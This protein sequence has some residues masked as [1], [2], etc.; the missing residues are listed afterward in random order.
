MRKW[1]S[2]ENPLG[3]FDNPLSSS[4]IVIELMSITIGWWKFTDRK[5]WGQILCIEKYTSKQYT[6]HKRGAHTKRN[7]I[8]INSNGGFNLSIP[9]SA[10]EGSINQR[11]CYNFIDSKKIHS[12]TWDNKMLAYRVDC[13]QCKTLQELPCR[14][15]RWYNKDRWIE[16]RIS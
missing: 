15:R 5:K 2:S 7:L 3:L 8:R 14:M 1:S 13:T 16:Q 12:W 4:K 11:R 6:I 9:T 10:S